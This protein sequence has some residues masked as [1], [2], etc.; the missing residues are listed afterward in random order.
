MDGTP[1]VSKDGL[2]LYFMSDRPGGFGGPDIWVSQRASRESQWGL[3]INLGEAVNTAALEGAPILSRDE[4]WLFFN[5]NRT[6]GFGLNDLWASYREH[7]KD[8]LGWQTPFNLG[9]GVNTPFQD[10]GAGYFEND[11]GGVPLLF[12]GSNRPGG[13]GFNDIY[14]NQL[15]PDGSVG[16]T[17]LVPELSSPAND[18]RPSVRF[19]GLEVFLFSNRPGSLGDTDLWVATRHTVFDLWSTPTN[20]GPVVNSAAAELQ[21]HIA[22]D[23]RTLYFASDRSGGFG[24]LDLYVTTRT[25]QNVAAHVKPRK[26]GPTSMRASAAY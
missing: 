10:Q 19:D 13:P 23:R 2:S 24:Q 21:Q 3:P 7:T 18:L 5:S 14:E 12:F 15:L 25:K 17:R 16:L 20:L 22:S 6:G 26:S 1:A 11:D 4:H 8:D 9:A